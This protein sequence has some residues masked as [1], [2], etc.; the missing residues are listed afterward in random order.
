MV[1]PFYNGK[2]WLSVDLTRKSVSIISSIRDT[3]LSKK[4]IEFFDY[5]VVNFMVGCMLIVF[6]IN[7]FN[8]FSPCSHNKNMSSM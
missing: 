2:G 7:D 4:F 8:L 3:V 6:S 5:S 1:C